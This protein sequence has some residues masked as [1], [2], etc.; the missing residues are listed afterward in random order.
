MLPLL[1]RV[2][3]T[4]SFQHT[5][6]FYKLHAGEDA[7]AECLAEHGGFSHNRQAL[8]IVEELERRYRRFPGLNL[9]RE[10]LAAQA[11]RTAKHAVAEGVAAAPLLEAQV[12]EAADSITYDAHDAD[13]AMKLGL[14]TLAELAEIPFVGEAL[15]RVQSRYGP[16]EGKLLHKGVIHEL[17]DWQVSDVLQH[18]GPRLALTGFHSAAA[19]QIAGP[20][21]CVGA[22]LGARKRELESFLYQRVYRHPQ[23]VAERGAAQ[24][25]LQT[26]FD[27][28]LA[29]P[30]LLPEKFRVRS[31]T[32]GLPRSVGDY[33]AGMTDRFCDE[34]FQRCFPA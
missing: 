24:H 10:T 30:E 11:T 4:A 2:S 22:E 21:V 33:L 1:A 28:Y 15:Q 18:S 20:L 19:A 23:L 12:V 5:Y 16:L 13:D 29:R 3:Q 27:G 25:R 7:L 32:A 34:Q 17:I 31:Q 6:P 26:M 8:I 9:T 14:V